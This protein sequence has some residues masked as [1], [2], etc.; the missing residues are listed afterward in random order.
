MQNKLQELTDRLYEEGLAKGK[1]EGAR[2]LAEAR[3]EAEAITAKARE[4]ADAVLAKA[5]KDA[6]DTR[7]KAESDIRMASA[8]ALQATRKDIEDVI[9]TGMCDK[10][11]EKAL[12]DG[13]FIKDIIRSVAAGFSSEGTKDMSMVLPESLNEKLEPYVREELGKVIGNGIDAS[14]TKKIAGGFKI[15]PKDGSYFISMTD[16]AFKALIAEYLRPVTRKILFG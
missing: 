15:G 12:S 2:I 3:A 14:F 16:E 7:A 5:G 4:E 6:A 8:Q 10:H 11:I 1:E 13:E 9:V